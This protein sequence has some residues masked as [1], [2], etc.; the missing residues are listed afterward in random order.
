M[1]NHPTGGFFIQIYSLGKIQQDDKDTDYDAM[2]IEIVIMV[3]MGIVI[4]IDMI[5]KRYDF[6]SYGS[7]LMMM[8]RAAV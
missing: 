5:M 4:M 7:A 1:V 8:V 3:I 2:M 6:E